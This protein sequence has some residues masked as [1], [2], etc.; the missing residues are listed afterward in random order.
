MPAGSP[1]PPRRC[2]TPGWTSPFTP[3]MTSA[4]PGTSF[5]KGRRSCAGRCSKPATRAPVPPRLTTCI[6][7]TSPRGSTLTGPRCRSPASSPA[8]RTTSCAASATRP[9]PPCQLDG[10]ADAGDKRRP[11]HHRCTVATHAGRRPGAVLPPS[12]RCRGWTAS[13]D[14]RGHTPAGPPHRSSCRRDR[15]C[16]ADRGKAGRPRHPHTPIPEL[17]PRR[18]HD[19]T[20]PSPVPPSSGTASARPTGY[21]RPA[22]WRRPGPARRPGPRRTRRRYPAP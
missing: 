2:G 1:P 3:P 16:L 11:S 6:T 18:T 13:R 4:P 5:T 10:D 9:T 17:P 20:Q 22:R 15:S 8:A 21:R 12:R 7:P 19:L 14:W